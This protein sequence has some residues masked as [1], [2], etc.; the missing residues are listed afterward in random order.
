MKE[1]VIT[2]GTPFSINQW[3][4]LCK[5]ESNFLQSTYYDNV[6]KQ[7]NNIP[8]YFN[9]IKDDKIKGGVKC[10]Y[11]QSKKLQF[12]IS[13]INKPLHVIGEPI[14][15]KLTNEEGNHLISEFNKY[16]SDSKFTEIKIKG[17]FGFDKQVFRLTNYTHSTLQTAYIDIT[18]PEDEI[19]LKIHPTH[20]RYIKK[21][22]KNPRISFSIENELFSEFHKVLLKTYEGQDNIKPPDYD[23]LYLFYKTFYDLDM[24]DLCF[25]KQN[26]DY[27]DCFLNAVLAIRYGKKVFYVYGGNVKNNLGTGVYIHWEMIKYYKQLGFNDVHLGALSVNDPN[28]K[29]GNTV[30]DFKLKLGS[31]QKKFVVEQKMASHVNRTIWKFMKTIYN[32]NK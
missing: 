5:N 16:I 15:D 28:N 10:F 25:V 1:V 14:I 32:G 4:M 13:L 26:T 2:V 31:Y 6:A 23:Y 22:T 29:K 24:L 8:I 30:A 3:N 11:W 9:Y 12:L 18:L 21:A 27:E 19:W 20:R 17:F 7:A